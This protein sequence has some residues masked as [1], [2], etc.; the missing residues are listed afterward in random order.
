MYGLI[1]E[2]LEHSYSKLIHEKLGFY[3]YELF[4]L[5]KAKLEPFLRSKE[6]KGL[7]VTIPYKKEVIPF[8]DSLSCAAQKI[9]SVNTL[10]RLPDGSV[11]GDNTDFSGFLAM[12][13][14]AK[15][16]FEGK[17]VL[18]L[19]S[20]GTSLTAKT[21]VDEKGG[22]PIVISRSGKNNYENLFLHKDADIIVNTTPIGMYPNTEGCPVDLTDFPKCSAV[23]DVIYNPFYTRLLLQAASLGISRIG[24]LHMLV[25]QAAKA[26]EI[27]TGQA[28][29]EQ[30]IDEIR[31]EIQSSLMNIVLIGMPG[32]GKS[33][34]G[35]S[36][37]A[38]LNM[39]FK[40]TDEEIEKKVNMPIPLY[41]EKFKESEF[42]KLEAQQAQ[43]LG[44]ERRRIIA[45]GGGIVKDSDNYFRLKQNGVLFFLQRDLALLS[46]KG[47]PLSKDRE[48]LKKLYDER[49]HLYE[50]FA[51][52]TVNS[53]ASIEEAANAIRKVLNR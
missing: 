44:K 52:Y 12:A 4:P 27:F 36:L 14:K 26:C 3:E 23:L 46:T 29:A 22:T 39:E 8:C 50:H 16:S 45:T 1:G 47:R 19:G 42:R 30:T 35:K 33:T 53:N 25:S 34:V 7:N 11:H 41:F 32:S 17:K 31:D 24:G 49:I 2:K 43:D 18:I 13:Q 28:I 21:A 51:D 5:P 38:A 37:A 40:D 20:G 6:W 15:I 10:V 48:A 9:G